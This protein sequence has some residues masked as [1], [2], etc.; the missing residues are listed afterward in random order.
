LPSQLQ[1]KTLLASERTQE[2]C[3][4]QVGALTTEIHEMFLVSA[5]KHKGNSRRN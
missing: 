4:I 5:E 3:E 1:Q 2:K